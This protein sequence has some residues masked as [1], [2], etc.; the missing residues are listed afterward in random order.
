[1]EAR[2]LTQGQTEMM[3]GVSQ[4]EISLYITGKRKMNADRFLLFLEK[5]GGEVRLKG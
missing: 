2:C 1:M 4:K 5:L 3:T